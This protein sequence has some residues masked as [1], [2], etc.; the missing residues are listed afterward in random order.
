[1]AS[2]KNLFDDVFHA[3]GDDDDIQQDEAVDFDDLAIEMES[4]NDI[5]VEHAD[6]DDDNQPEE[7]IVVEEQRLSQR[8]SQLSASHE[9]SAVPKEPATTQKRPPT[10]TTESTITIVKKFKADTPANDEQMPPYLRASHRLFDETMAPFLQREM[11]SMN[12]E[13]LR[14]VANLVHD[15]NLTNLLISQWQ[16]YLQSGTG[17]LKVSFPQQQRLRLKTYPSIWPVEVKK[18][19]LR[20][21]AVNARTESDIDGT[22]C[23]SF[24]QQYL[25]RL[26]SGVQN[27]ESQLNHR[28][29]HLR[30]LTDEMQQAIEQY[31]F[32]HCMNE[33]DLRI[34]K[35]ILVVEY[36][37]RDR[38]LELEFEE[39]KPNESQ[40]RL[41]RALYQ[42]KAEYEKSKADAD[43]LKQHV[44]YKTFPESFET[45]RFPL[46]NELESIT[47]PSM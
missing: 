46:P 28:K 36:N 45:F 21:G 1:M 47:D 32:Q 27:L 37:Y 8:L 17:Q 31:V 14:H 29:R 7:S 43:I 18:A 6:V 11:S 13:D 38:L 19:M 40:L 4:K 20:E 26:R 44:F 2:S 3:R 9:P 22:Q 10:T 41:Y 30:G 5:Q 16:M 39:L 34:Q 23:L 24:T 35:N 15:L 42:A 12:I 25:G 33:A